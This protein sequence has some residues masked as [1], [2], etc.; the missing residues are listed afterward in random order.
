MPLNTGGIGV[1]QGGS[2]VPIEWVLTAAP[3]SRGIPDGGGGQ[4]PQQPQPKPRG[5]ASR[6][7]FGSC[8]G[9][10]LTE[11]GEAVGLPLAGIGGGMAAAGLQALKVGTSELSGAGLLTALRNSLLYSEP[12]TVGGWMGAGAAEVSIS[13][14]TF[15]VGVPLAFAVGVVAGEAIACAIEYALP[16]PANWLEK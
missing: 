7:R 4:Q 9:R 3:G 2:W 8:V 6:D 11:F 1:C 15:S 10:R 16:G 14:G 5:P 13:V 12:L